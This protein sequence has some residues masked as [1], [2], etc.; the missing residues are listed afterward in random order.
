M[1]GTIIMKNRLTIKE[2]IYIGSMLFGLFFGAGNL[3]FPI[4]LGQSA[5]ANVLTANLGFLITAIGLPFL[6][7]IAIGVSKTNGLFEISTRVNKTYAYIFTIA[8][9]LVIGPFFALPRLATTS[10]EIAF[11]PFISGKSATLFLSV[12]SILFFLVAWFFARKPSKILDYIG[13]FLNPIFLILL[14][15]IIL[16]A[17]INPIGNISDA[18]IDPQYKD[19]SLLKG[20]IDGYNTLD[21]LASLAFGIIIVSTIKKLGITNPNEIAKET[22]KSGTISIVLMG[23]IYSLLAVMGTMSLGHFKVSENGGIALAQIAKYYLGDYG[24][25]L[26]SLIIIVAC[27]KTAIGLI[28]AFSETF[29]ELFPKQNYLMFATVVSIISCVFA[30]VGLTKIIEYSTPVLMFLYPLAI[31]LILLTLVSTTFNHSKIVYQ[32]T[33][34]FTMIASFLDGI[35][36]SPDF[37]VNTKFSEVVLTFGEKCLPF[38]TIGMGWV[39]PSIIGFII[40]FII[41]KIKHT[42]QP[43]TVS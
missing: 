30:N 19:S 37:I 8:L 11:S 27:L 22:V 3:I 18:T 2:N 15:L 7:I 13:K 40:G 16:L 24:I 25:I 1:W 6:G 41:Y 34:Y 36:A 23:V 17:F 29:T 21:A 39:L 38:F 33:T 20:F 4:H 31:T 26:L 10:F 32:F 9:Y 43:H 35:K 12:F 5:G 28:T 42:R 14:G